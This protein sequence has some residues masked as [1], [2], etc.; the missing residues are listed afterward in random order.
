MKATT[1]LREILSRDKATI[2][3]AVGDPLSAL[4]A[5]AEGYEGVMVSGNATS[6]TRLGMPDVGLLTMTENADNVARIFDA[7]GLPVF[8]DADT[9]YGNAI[10]VKRTIREFERAGAAAIMIED[11][12]SPKR[13]GMLAGKA[14]IPISEMEDKLRSAVDSRR[15]PDLVIV[16]R[17]DA[18]SVEGLDAAIE[19][20][21]RYAEAGADAIFVQGPRG[22]DEAERL[23]AEIDRPQFY[24]VTPDGKTPSL[25]QEQLSLLGFKV[26]GFSV[27]LLL[28]AIPAMRGLLRKLADTGSL[29]AAIGGAA[30]LDEYH[31]LLDLE[32]WNALRQTSDARAG[33]R[34]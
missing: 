12:V 18:R 27:Y 9:G 15:D 13:C 30:S 22:K 2:L 34:P 1:R 25:T 28:M 33:G 29:E 19:R 32:D 26:M 7:T 14:L 3:P 10:T 5:R 6:A 11:Q 31:N 4:L 17:T 23:V 16:G 8:A 24:I 20:A 21:C